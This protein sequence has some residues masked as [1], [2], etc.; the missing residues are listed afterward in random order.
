MY[1]LYRQ[2][3]AVCAILS[4]YWF[5][6]SFLFLSFLHAFFKS[7]THPMMLYCHLLRPTPIYPPTSTTSCNS[8]QSKCTMNTLCPPMTTGLVNLSGCS[9][10]QPKIPKF[11]AI[12]H[13]S[14]T[15]TCRWFVIFWRS[16]FI[17]PVLTAWTACNSFIPRPT[18]QNW[19]L[20]LE[21]FHLLPRLL[22]CLPVTV[23]FK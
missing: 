17:A 15:S 20:N 5:L 9:S 7:S 14:A 3:L 4:L 19:A 1:N 11:A 23:H 21:I 2:K 8:I 12:N 6:I 10:N 13:M 18:A 22:T 16:Y